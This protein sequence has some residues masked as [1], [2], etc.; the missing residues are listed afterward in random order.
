M[1]RMATI[2]SIIAVLSPAQTAFVDAGLLSTV[3]VG[4]SIVEDLNLDGIP[5][6]V[7]AAPGVPAQLTVLL[8]TGPATWSATSI[9]NGLDVVRAAGDVNGDGLPDLVGTYSGWIAT[10][11]GDGTG[12]FSTPVLSAL[13]PGWPTG[14]END[15]AP[16]ADLDGDGYPEL[17]ARVESTGYFNRRLTLGL[18]DGRFVAHT[19]P[20]LTVASSRGLSVADLDNDGDTDIVDSGTWARP[21]IVWNNGAGVLTPQ[22]ALSTTPALGGYLRV[23]DVDG[24]GL[25]DIVGEVIGITINNSLVAVGVLRGIG[26][27]AFAPPQVTYLAIPVAGRSRIS[28]G[29]LDQDG[30]QDVYLMGEVMAGPGVVASRN[31]AFAFGGPSGFAPFRES[32]WAGSTGYRTHLVDVDQDGDLDV[33]FTTDSPFTPAIGLHLN[34]KLGVHPAASGTFFGGCGSTTTIG[35]TGGL[36]PGATAIVDVTGAVGSGPAFLLVSSTPTQA[37]WS[38]CVFAVGPTSPSTIAL[39]HT[40][41]ASG[42]A[43]VPVLLP[44]DPSLSGVRVYAQ[45]WW[46]DGSTTLGWNGTLG[47]MVVIG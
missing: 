46:P 31:A 4:A 9:V 36:A 6:F 30:F 2:F 16:L 1:T 5:D 14:A 45:D 15:R 26:G 12:Q 27:G 13:R 20:I 37:L 40:I 19:L 33:T 43:T 23:T 44:N 11:L 38:D 8:S 34:L 47:L 25:V 7:G 42:A 18:G 29:D 10:L 28:V 24:D 22:P 32:G 35:V 39:P 41:D 3:S 21:T 17:I